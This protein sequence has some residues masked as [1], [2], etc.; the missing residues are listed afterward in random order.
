MQSTKTTGKYNYHIV[1]SHASENP[2]QPRAR[3]Q[4]SHLWDADFS[5]STTKQICRVLTVNYT[6]G[7]Q[8]KGC[9]LHFAQ[10]ELRGSA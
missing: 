10:N 9:H 2:E 3:R 6:G 7:L 1:T 4:T 5:A 8:H